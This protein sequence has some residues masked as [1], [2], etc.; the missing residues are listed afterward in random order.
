VETPINIA[1]KL[2]RVMRETVMLHI[3]R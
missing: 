2:R 1:N 3:S